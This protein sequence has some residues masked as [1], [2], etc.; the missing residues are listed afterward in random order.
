MQIKSTDLEY[1]VMLI[2]NYG[3]LLEVHPTSH[4]GY[5]T[6]NPMKYRGHFNKQLD[7]SGQLSARKTRDWFYGQL[8]SCIHRLQLNTEVSVDYCK[9]NWNQNQNQNHH[10][11]TA[12]TTV[13]TLT[14]ATTATAIPLTHYHYHTNTGGGLLAT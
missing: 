7:S 4:P 6:L 11:T 2:L 1:D 12:I 13:A 9:R 14:T 3:E 8:Q 5:F 10:A